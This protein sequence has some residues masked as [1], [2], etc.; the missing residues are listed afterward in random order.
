MTT[1]EVSVYAQGLTKHFA[2]QRGLLAVLRGATRAPVTVIDGIDLTLRRG[3]IFGLLGLNGAGKT[4]LVRMLCGLLIPSAG[5]ATVG[6][7]DLIRQPRQVRAAVGLVAGEDRSFFWRLTARQN[8]TF[9]ADLH[10]LP[11]REGQ[12]RVS[13]LLDLFGLAD[14]ADRAVGLFS[15]GMRQKLA[16]ARAL[17]H[18]PQ[19]LFLDEPTRGLDVQAADMLLTTIRELA[20]QHGTTILLTTHQLADAEH[21]CDCVGILHHGRLQAVGAPAALRNHLHLCTRYRVQVSRVPAA[22]VTDLQHLSPQLACEHINGTSVLAFS[23][24]DGLT[25]DAVLRTLYRVDARVASVEQL[26]PS[27]A[28]VVRSV[29]NQT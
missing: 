21:I 6:G 16:L 11:Q 18:R 25:L 2:Q 14:A 22:V 8:L 9:F 13:D 29:V 20:A 3:E 10:R 27:L 12:R 23:A 5:R 19:V 15:T 4:T 24:T 28:D 1:P 7:V 17:M 26:T